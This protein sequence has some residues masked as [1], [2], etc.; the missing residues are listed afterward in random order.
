MPEVRIRNK[1]KI[2][3]VNTSAAKAHEGNL[4]VKVEGGSVV[5]DA[6]TLHRLVGYSLQPSHH[7]SFLNT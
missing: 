3:T 2:K 5:K 4:E 7:I 1:K 6:S